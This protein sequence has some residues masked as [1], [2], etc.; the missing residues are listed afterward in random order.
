MNLPVYDFRNDIRNVLVT[1]K[2]RSRFMQ[3]DPGTYAEPHSHDLGHEI[4]IV[5]QGSAIFEIDGKAGE[6]GPGQMCVALAHQLHSIQV[7]SKEPMIIYL[8][9]T[10][11]IIPTHTSCTDSGDKKPYRYG[12]PGDYDQPVPNKSIGE[13]AE[14]VAKSASELAEAAQVTAELSNKLPNS[15]KQVVGNRDFNAIHSIRE[16]LLGSLLLLYDLAD[17]LAYDWNDFSP[18]IE[19][20]IR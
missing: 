3:L 7:T 8:S 6:V 14:Q 2:I 18:A 17:K 16:S 5:M 1:P 20:V 9:V 4:F 15:V 13:L 19:D 12:P 10:P 11:H